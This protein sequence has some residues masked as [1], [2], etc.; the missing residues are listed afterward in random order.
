LRFEFGHERLQTIHF[1]TK[2]PHMGVVVRPD[3]SDGATPLFYR[4]FLIEN[5]NE[6]HVARSEVVSKGESIIVL[7]RELHG[8]THDVTIE[9]NHRSQLVGEEAKVSK[10]FDHG[11]GDR[12]KNSNAKVDS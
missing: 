10:F 9:R 6:G 8:E 7:H 3:V 11:A 12:L 4:A 2:V 5:L 1:K